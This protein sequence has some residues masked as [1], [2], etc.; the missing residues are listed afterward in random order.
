MFSSS[1]RQQSRPFKLETN[2]FEAEQWEWQGMPVGLKF[3][4][5]ISTYS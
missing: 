2:D 3:A 4:P 1:Y 5:S